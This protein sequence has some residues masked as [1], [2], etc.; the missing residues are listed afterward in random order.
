MT[1]QLLDFTDEVV[2]VIGAA[3]GI[4]RATALAFA[5]R[6]ATIAVGDVDERAA[7]TVQAFQDRGG[8][9]RS[10]PTDVTDER[11]V[12]TVVDEQ[13]GCMPHS[14]TPV[15]CPPRSHWLKWMKKIRTEPSVSISKGCS[16]RSNTR[17]RT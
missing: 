4:G 9:A 5:D 6:G 14:T 12:R 17:S 7:Q 15:C 10:I 13:G 11:L 2:L 16:S 8:E 1:E 3:T